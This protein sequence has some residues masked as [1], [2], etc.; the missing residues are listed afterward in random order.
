MQFDFLIGT[1]LLDVALA[2]G[3]LDVMIGQT[4]D[5]CEVTERTQINHHQI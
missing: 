5:T 3:V 2:D 4:E 1:G